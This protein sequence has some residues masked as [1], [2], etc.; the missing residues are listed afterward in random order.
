MPQQE[1]AGSSAADAD[2]AED[3]DAG[4]ADGDTGAQEER[5]FGGDE[6]GEEGGYE[7]DDE[8]DDGV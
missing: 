1:E 4:G 3:S 5:G 6:G 2:G 8:G 7:G